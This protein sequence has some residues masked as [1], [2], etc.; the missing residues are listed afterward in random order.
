M[1]WHALAGVV[2]MLSPGDQAAIPSEA[3]IEKVPPVVTGEIVDVLPE[4]FIGETIDFNTDRYRRMTV[5]VTI[6]GSGPFRFMIDTGAQ[7]TVLSSA[8]AD[9]LMLHDRRPGILVGMSSTRRVEVT[10]VPDVTL[11]SRTLS[12]R[13]APLVPV[14]N[15]G[16]ADG[17]L[18]LDML[19]NQ[20]VLLDF[21]KRQ[22]HVAEAGE[23][24][25]DRGYD[26][27]VRARR[28]LGQLIIADARL[29][30]VRVAV[31]I[32]TGAQGSIGNEELF[33]RLRRGHDRGDT[34]M[35]DIN[36]VTRAGTFRNAERL[37]LGSARLTDFPI[38]FTQSPTFAALGLDDR[39]AMVLGMN[40]MRA[41]D[42]VAID[43]ASRRVLFD[44]PDDQ[45]RV[46][47]D[48]LYR[49]GRRR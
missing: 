37:Q 43:F 38:A 35:T 28:H 41:F 49:S 4:G 11:G 25:G 39:P 15:I 22:I 17:I 6:M 33:R 34:A 21:A 19:Q 24:G 26:I 45:L 32:D 18:G 40:E 7:A 5:P 27:I 36:G 16:G 42:R 10:Q 8:L 20:R 46:V 14:Q 44:V 13:Q 29:N 2:A 48:P 1:Y 23:L 47:H 9:R 31:V 30:G 3:M 12:V